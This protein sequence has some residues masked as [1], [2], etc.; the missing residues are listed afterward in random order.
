MVINRA[1]I[2]IIPSVV[3]ELSLTRRLTS[4]FLTSVVG[5]VL[6]LKTNRGE[7]ENSVNNR[8]GNIDLHRL[9]IVGRLVTRVHFTETGTEMVTTTTL[10]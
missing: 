2:G 4:V 3:L 6:I 1:R 10:V 7:A 8:T 9:H 5:V